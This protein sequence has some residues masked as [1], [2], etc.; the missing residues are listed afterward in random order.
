MSSALTR[1]R[2]MAWVVGVL[3]VVLVL[4]GMPLKYLA[5]S[6]DV[7]HVVGVAHGFLF[8]VYLA[9]A[10]QLALRRRWQ[11]GFTLLVLVSG[12][13]PFLSFVMERR[14][15]ARERSVLPG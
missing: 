8:M 3:L 10:L 15:T 9:T 4:I 1:Y 14:V 13:V 6:P 11:L 2:A 12:T 7:V 5:D